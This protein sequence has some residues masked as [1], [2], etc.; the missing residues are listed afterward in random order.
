MKQLLAHIHRYLRRKLKELN[1]QFITIHVWVP[2][3]V[4]RDLEDE[5]PKSTFVE[6]DWPD[7][8]VL[9]FTPTPEEE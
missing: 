8:T 4:H 1:P 7:E 2:P 5:F 9:S 6:G 3:N